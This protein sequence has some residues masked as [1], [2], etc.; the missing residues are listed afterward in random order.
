M[1]KSVKLAIAAAI[2]LIFAPTAGTTQDSDTDNLRL[3]SNETVN[4]WIKRHRAAQKKQKE[5]IMP[6]KKEIN[7]K[8]PESFAITAPKGL[9]GICY[10]GPCYRPLD[11][12]R[13]VCYYDYDGWCQDCGWE[14]DPVCEPY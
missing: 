7:P 5:L 3:P 1:L 10:I 8:S 9:G 14:W 12:T 6:E 4:M 11:G 13:E 2:F